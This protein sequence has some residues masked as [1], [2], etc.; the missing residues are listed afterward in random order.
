VGD[1][2]DLEYAFPYGKGGYSSNLSKQDGIANVT[3]QCG[4]TNIG[5]YNLL[6]I[7]NSGNEIMTDD[8]LI[9][10]RNGEIKEVKIGD[11]LTLSYRLYI[12]CHPMDNFDPSNYRNWDQ[13]AG[14]PDYKLRFRFER[15]RGI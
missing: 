3:L 13:T 15:E 5:P 7:L 4:Y 8:S 12:D 2:V 9:T 10:H 14:Y 1:L 6:G 11:T